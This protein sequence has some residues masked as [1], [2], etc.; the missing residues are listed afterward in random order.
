M[1]DTIAESDYIGA[2]RTDKGVHAVNNVLSIVVN[3]NLTKAEIEE[4]K[5]ENERDFV[6][7]MNR[8]LPHDI[9]VT[10]WAPVEMNFSARFSCKS[11]SYKYVFES[12]GLDLSR[13]N[14]AAGKLIGQYDYRN[15]STAQLERQDTNR[16]CFLAKVEPISEHLG[17]FFF[18]KIRF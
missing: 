6:S 10:S 13:M 9:V 4:Q 15:F 18:P 3:S 16:E 14:E 1:I 7:M 5:T 2:A 8:H 11:R 17:M 12:A